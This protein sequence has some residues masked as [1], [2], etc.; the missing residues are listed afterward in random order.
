MPS[1]SH[2]QFMEFAVNMPEQLPQVGQ[3]VSSRAASSSAVMVP[4]A[5]FPAPSKSVFR[6]VEPSPSG[7]VPGSMGPPETNT[8]GTFA[9][10]AP[11]IMPGTILSQF[12]MHTRPSKACPM[13]AHSTESAMTSRD[14]S[15]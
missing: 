8:V 12:G 2:R 13:T 6:S 11:K 9:R 1:A 15:E 7:P 5:T 10:S 14:T 4:A 3:A